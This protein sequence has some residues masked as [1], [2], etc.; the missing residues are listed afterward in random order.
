MKNILSIKLTNKKQKWGTKC[1]IILQTVL[2]K[3]K[4]HKPENVIL[5]HGGDILSRHSILKEYTT[6]KLI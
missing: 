5:Q 1:F 6:Q 4:P 3:K 2:R